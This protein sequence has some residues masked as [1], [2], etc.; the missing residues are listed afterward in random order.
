MPI[1]NNE[2]AQLR[3]IQVSIPLT[4]PSKETRA[5]LVAHKEWSQYMSNEWFT[6][7]SLITD[8]ISNK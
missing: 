4:T 5:E 7:G 1:G 6:A 8:E 3:T 2:I